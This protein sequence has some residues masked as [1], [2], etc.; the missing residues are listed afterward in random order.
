MPYIYLAL[1]ITG[2]LIGTTLLKYSNGF[3]NITYGILSIVVYGICFLFLAKAMENINLSIVYATW[4]GVG[5]V[6]TTLISI[7]IFKEHINPV[8]I[9]GIILTISGVILL[10]L[11]NNVH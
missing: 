7:F 1:A 2:E 4:S 8:G 10:N 11:F 5:I 6:A 3:K 9:L